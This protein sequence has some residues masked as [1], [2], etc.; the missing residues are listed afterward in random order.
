MPW[1]PDDRLNMCEG[2]LQSIE[3]WVVRHYNG[4]RAPILSLKSDDFGQHDNNP[5]SCQMCSGDPAVTV[6][7]FAS[8]HYIQTCDIERFGRPIRI[9][10]KYI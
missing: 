5:T 4:R 1:T 3:Q 10:K 6:S 9:N 2:D 7:I 8:I